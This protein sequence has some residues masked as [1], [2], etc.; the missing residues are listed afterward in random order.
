MQNLVLKFS[1]ED[2][3]SKQYS[4]ISK[5]V[6][7]SCYLIWLSRSVQEIVCLSHT[8]FEEHSD[9]KKNTLFFL[10][11]KTS[12]VFSTLANMN[13]KFYLLGPKKQNGCSLEHSANESDIS[14]HD[15][16]TF[17]ALEKSALEYT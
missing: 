9:Q 5:L 12:E 7:N 4:E 14:I 15:G 2:L 13:S 16:Q 11:D 6:G 1:R 10:V 3:E 8:I 17:D